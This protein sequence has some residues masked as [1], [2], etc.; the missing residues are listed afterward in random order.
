MADQVAQ[1]AISF[2]YEH[3]GHA[4]KAATVNLSGATL[5]ITLHEALSAA[6]CALARTPEGAARVQEFHRALF[7]SSAQPLRQEIQR[8]T[9]VPV[10]QSGV[11]ME[12]A[13]GAVVHAFSSG[14]MVQVFQL[15]Q[16]IPRDAW[17]APGTNVES[18]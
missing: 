15:D 13:S 14:T 2:Q 1:A 11:E 8:I 7:G 6:E 9:G 5:V 4:P 10:R 12:I 16:A 17:D 3:T 18:E